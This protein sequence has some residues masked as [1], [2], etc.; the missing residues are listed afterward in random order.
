M[1]YADFIDCIDSAKERTGSLSPCDFR[2]NGEVAGTI[3]Q[4]AEVASID[5]CEE[6]SDI[7][8]ICSVDFINYRCFIYSVDSIDSIE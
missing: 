7:S 3:P 2:Q 6:C 4:N 5:S 1:L 8:Y